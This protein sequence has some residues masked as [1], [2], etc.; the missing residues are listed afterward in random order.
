MNR[1]PATIIT[2]FHNTDL[3]LFRKAFDSVLSQTIGIDSIEWII[4]VHNSEPGYLESVMKITEDYDTIKVYELNNNIRT[5]SGPRNFALERAHGKYLFFL[6]S[7]DRM[8]PC[9]IEKVTEKM[10]ET[11]AEICKFRAWKELEDNTVID[12]YDL[13]VR[14]DQ[15]KELIEYTKGDPGIRDILTVTSLT[16][17]TQA[18]SRDM[19][20]NRHIRFNPETEIGEDCEFNV[21]CINYADRIIV[22]PRL[23]G[24]V[25]YVNHSSAIQLGGPLSP[26]SVMRRTKDLFKCIDMGINYG[27]DMRYLFWSYAFGLSI[28]LIRMPQITIEQRAEFRDTFGKYF[29]LIEP[30]ESDDRFFPGTMAQRH[31]DFCRFIILGNAWDR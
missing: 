21:K 31:M 17:W 6:D 11:G 28:S 14:F 16:L 20:E 10:E 18:L 1:F 15:T 23:I 22:L 26:E 7:D 3:R 24:Y 5:A 29:D 19:V 13:R 25:Y 12:I 8:T 4:V 30:L 9:C 27:L 2:P